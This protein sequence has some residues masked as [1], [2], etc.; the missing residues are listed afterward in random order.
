MTATGILVVRLVFRVWSRGVVLC[1]NPRFLAYFF[2]LIKNI[3]LTSWGVVLYWKGRLRAFL[4]SSIDFYHF[5]TSDRRMQD[6]A[7]LHNFNNIQ[8]LTRQQC[9][10]FWFIF[11][12]IIY[13]WIFIIIYR[14]LNSSIKNITHFSLSQ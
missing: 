13:P 2:L 5:W 10:N 1:W 12:I 11:F 8:Y 7:G 9:Y 4:F 6:A 3:F 14:E